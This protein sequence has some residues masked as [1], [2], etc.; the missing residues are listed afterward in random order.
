MPLGAF[1]ENITFANTINLLSGLRFDN[2][3]S[4][5]LIKIYSNSFISLQLVTLNLMLLT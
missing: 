1:I 4:K 5:F 3:L 2:K